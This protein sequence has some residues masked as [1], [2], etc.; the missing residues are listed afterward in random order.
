M[1]KEELRS[2]A[3]NFERVAAR[4]LLDP[5]VAGLC[6]SLESLLMQARQG[7]IDEPV[8]QVPGEHYFQEGLLSG[9]SDLEEAYSKLKLR[10]VTDS[11]QYD[12]LLRWAED[13]RRRLFGK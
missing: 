9:Y 5:D 1:D 10:L 3:E 2:L 4:Y 7:L 11:E 13:R 12:D 8:R 6:S